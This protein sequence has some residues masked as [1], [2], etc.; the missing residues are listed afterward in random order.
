VVRRGV[1]GVGDAGLVARPDEQHEE[2]E[3]TD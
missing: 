2:F 1:D 3:G